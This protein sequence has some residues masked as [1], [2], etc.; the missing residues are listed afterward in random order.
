MPQALVP[1]IANLGAAIGGVTGA[2]LIMNA[3]AI[4]VGSTIMGS[5]T[6][7]GPK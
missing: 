4:A 3:T 7:K 2:V 1:V 5:A 6:L